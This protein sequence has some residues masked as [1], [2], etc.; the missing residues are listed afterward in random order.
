MIAFAF[1]VGVPFAPPPATALVGLAQGDALAAVVATAGA[2]A[3]FLCPNSELI[4]LIADVV[5]ETASA[6]PL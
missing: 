5:L 1:G 6:A 4:L 3:G 2:A